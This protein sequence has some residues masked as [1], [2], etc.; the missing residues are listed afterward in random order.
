MELD[1]ILQVHVTGTTLQMEAVQYA[2]KIK[3]CIVSCPFLD[4]LS[5]FS[6][7]QEMKNSFV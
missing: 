2:G 5:K 4:W 7:Y 6:F 3:Q 1:Y